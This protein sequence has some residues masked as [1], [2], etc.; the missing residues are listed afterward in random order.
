MKI[1]LKIIICALVVI[2]LTGS[3]AYEFKLPSGTGVV[4]VRDYGAKGDGKADDTEAINKAIAF[5]FE[6]PDTYNRYRN[7]GILYFPAGT[8]K[9]TG[10]VM[11]KVLNTGW[12]GGWRSGM[13]LLGESRDKTVIRLADNTEGYG[14]AEKPRYVVATGSESDD[15]NKETS[16]GG[17]RAFRHNIVNLTIDVGH[18]NPGAIALDY[19]V[20]NRGCVEDVLLR[21]PEGSGYCGLNLERHW[22]GPALIKRLEIQGF[23]YGI[24]VGHFQY[25]M[26]FEH[27]KLVNP[28]VCGIRNS[29]NVLAIRKLDAVAKVPIVDA[30]GEHSTIVLM[31]SVLKAAPGTPPGTV[32]FQNK[33][34]VYLRDVKVEGFATALNDERGK[35]VIPA[36]SDALTFYAQPGF[37]TDSG[38]VKPMKLPVKETLEFHS[39]RLSDW[40]NVAD[41]PAEDPADSIQKAI[42]SGKPIVYLPNASYALQKTVILRGKVRKI[43]GFCANITTPDGVPAFR[44]EKLD[45]PGVTLEHITAASS[46]IVQ[47]GDKALA[48]RHMDFGNVSSTP[49]ATGDIFL[50]DTIGKPITVG[51]GVSL[52]GRQVNC[53]FGKDPLIV[54]HGNLW[55]LGYKTEGEMICLDNRKGGRAEVLGALLYPLRH[56][57]P[58]APMFRNDGGV[59]SLCYRQNGN[60]QYNTHLENNGETLTG[61][62]LKTSG[63]GICNAQ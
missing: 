17:N 62:Q 9:V 27:I 14:D 19:V 6:T 50:E 45:G 55:L 26:T 21:A 41:Y 63:F 18:G 51:T 52:W 36:T 29:Q 8:Y 56:P 53:E 33:G 28:R 30:R 15:H 2:P 60:T 5:I 46:A 54:N 40:V 38:E 48:L 49:G 58:D 23:D 12:A 24:R 34:R 22:P 3:L 20:S 13:F 42:D 32:A 37:S 35:K 10:P 44:V 61:S 11:S 4:N 7:Q 16:G 1:W 47:A 59:L 39:T 25:S 31:D 43:I 57:A